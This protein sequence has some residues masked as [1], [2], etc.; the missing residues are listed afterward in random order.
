MSLRA[1]HHGYT[2]QDLVTGIALVDLLLGTATAI[3]V[4]V[5]GFDGDRFDDLTIRYEDNRR[6]RIQIKHTTQDRE[7]SK[8]SFSADS[9]SLKL[10]ILS[11]SLL[12]DLAKHPGTV[13]RV[14]V[15]DGTP[16]QDLAEVLKPVGSSTD[17]G[18][19][20]PGFKTQSFRF[21]REQL[22]SRSPWKKL[23]EHLSDSE[24][25]S[26]CTHLIVD[27]NAPSS[28]VDMSTPGPAERALLR[29]V[30]EEL[31]AGRPPNAERA[32]EDVAL[33]LAYAATAARTL[34][35]SVARRD[36]VP[37]IGL[38]VDFGAVAEGHPIETNLA[39][40]RVRAVTDMRRHVSL[41][42][43]R[44]G[45][46]VVTGEPGA[47][48]SW[49]CQELAASYRASHW[50]V[51][52]HHCWL[53]ANDVDRDKRALTEVVVGSLLRQLEQAAPLATANLRPRFAATTEAL[54]A[55]LAACQERYPT[56]QVLLIVDGLDHVDRVLGR[57]SKDRLD[58]SQVL[59]DQLAA[60]ELPP[61][62]CLVIASQPGSHLRDARPSTGHTVQMPRMSWNEIRD[63][64]LR[65]RLVGQERAT[66]G[67]STVPTE[68]RNLIDLLHDRS[69]GNA[70]YATYLCRYG[71][72]ISPLDADQ[73]AITAKEVIH[74]L[75]LVPSTAND[76][77]AYYGYLLADLTGDQELAIG[78]LA[79]CDFALTASEL[80][81][82][83][84]EAS[85]I[86]ER[87][88]T[89][90]APVLNSQ[91][92]L[93]GL[94]IHH[95][96]FSRHILRDQ[97]E[98]WI[99]TIREKAAAWLAAK[100]FFSDARAFRHLPE[101]LVRL[102]RY[103]ELKELIKPGFVANAIQMLQPP[104]A[105]KHVV[106]TLARESATRLDWPS[107]TACIETW[108]SI[109]TYESEA[110]S[111][112]LIEYADVV[113]SILGPDVVAE[114]L[115]YEGRPTF[116]ARWGLRLCRSVDR[117]GGSA[118]W[119]AYLRAHKN[120]KERESVTYSSDSDDSLHLAIQLGSLRLTGQKNGIKPGLIDKIAANLDGKSVGDLKALVE[121]FSV[122][123]PPGMMIDVV[124]KMT[125]S[126][127]TAH[128]Y[129]ALA[130]LATE[131]TIGLPDPSELADSAWHLS[132]SANIIRYLS[133]GITP[134]KVLSG[135]GLSNLEEHLH[136][137]TKTILD[138]PSAQFE[139][140]HNWLGLL[141][142]AR[143]IDS[144]I[145]VR[146]IGQLGGSGFYRA[147]LRF[148]AATVGIADD[149]KK[150][151]IKAQT[152]SETVRVAL[153]QL[154]VHA[155]PF[156]GTPR[157]CDLYFVHPL[158]HD[159]VEQS[160]KVV[161][162]ADLEAVVDNL[163]AIGDGTTT[164]LMG[165][166]ENGP[167]ATNDLLAI[168]SRVADDVGVQ[169]VHQVLGVIRQRRN[170]ANT[171]YSV[172]AD[173]ELATAR[174]CVGAGATNEAMECWRRAA[175]LLASYGGH[176]DPTIYE[177]MD[178]IKDLAAVDVESAR[179]SLARILDASYLVRQHTDGRGTSNVPNSWW[180]TL[181]S[182]DPI[183]SA[184]DAANVLV[185][186]PGFEDARAQTVYEKLLETQ[187]KAADPIALAS[188]R[189]AA[190]TT[191]RDPNTDLLLL[192]RL[193]TEIG[194]STASSSVITSYANNVAASYDDQPLMYAGERTQSVATSELISE[195]LALGG[196]EFGIRKAHNNQRRNSLAKDAVPTAADLKQRLL[197]AQRPDLPEG[198]AGAVAAARDYAR[199]DY[200]HNAYAPRW[201]IDALVN[202][203]G[204]RVFEATQ[205][206]GRESGIDLLDDVA[207]ELSVY[208]DNE[209]FA[210]L[211]EGLAARCGSATTD[212][213]SVASY[214]LVLAFTRIRGGGGWRRFAGTERVNL[215]IKAHLLDAET[216]E[217]TLAQAVITIMTLGKES[218]YGVTQ[219][220]VA[221]LAAQPSR[222]PDGTAIDCWNA[223]C[224]VLLDRMH[225]EA[226]KAHHIYKA[227]PIPDS[228]GEL[229]VAL[230]TLSLAAISQPKRS[231]L[232][233]ALLAAA[234]LIAARPKVAQQALVPL[235]GHR[236][237]AGR[238]TWLLEIVA[239]FLPSGELSRS[240]SEAL[241]RLSQSEKL[242]VRVLASKI[243]RS[244]KQNVAH[245]PATVP[246]AQSKRPSNG[247]DRGSLEDA[248]LLVNEMLADRL[249]EIG[250]YP[251]LFED[252]V[253]G[254]A[255][256]VDVVSERVRQQFEH[257]RSGHS[258]R[259]P[260]AFFA[261]EE[262]AEDELQVAAAGVRATLAGMGLIGDPTA[263]EE[264]IAQ[265]LSLTGM[266]S[267]R[268]E[269]SQVARPVTRA[270]DIRW[271]L[272]PVPWLGN[273]MLWP[274]SEA[275]A[276]E[277]TRNL[278][279]VLSRGVLVEENPYRG[280]V[281]L[282]LIE[283]MRT[284][285]IDY[286][287]APARNLFVVTGL[288]TDA[289][290][291]AGSY[292]LSASPPDLWVR[293]YG[294]LM[295]GLDSQRARKTLS[296]ARGP[297]VALADQNERRVGPQRGAGLHPFLLSP[298]IEVV[299]ALALRPASPADRYLLVDDA[300]PAA[301]CRQWGSFLIHD[302]SYSDLVPAVH[303]ADLILRRDLFDKVVNMVGSER[304][305]LGLTGHH[306]SDDKTDE[307]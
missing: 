36:V 81:E 277:K 252:V 166:A 194:T 273:D 282:A 151:V 122:C 54:E 183:A 116:S 67:P 154:V 229:D 92:G 199:K 276:L 8:A 20:L 101:L 88:L 287:A 256:R 89:K 177:F 217:R 102:D 79:L 21:D 165:M 56:R 126:D 178:S 97:P 291:S 222:Q 149:V 145:P 143:E 82:M 283:R 147:W 249:D 78:T 221:A 210:L 167:L 278:T 234:L 50:I 228:D 258:K 260:D 265:D 192:K 75:G 204:W 61:G 305:S 300:G 38:T 131:G 15:R 123:L 96:S 171:M 128:V 85:L 80:S 175:K 53:G 120:A 261:D 76:L 99:T 77:D 107:L 51:A 275:V 3:D 19:P 294:D 263:I 158:I 104:E 250:E 188:L 269:A 115:L 18:D 193:Q 281:Q 189:L 225:G 176:K 55:A 218:T 280:W 118:P 302:G 226:E 6:V 46:I 292:P 243:L 40:S 100:G 289:S 266:W 57:T 58:P 9:R 156:T 106:S 163:I 65:H 111:D 4:D 139:A 267:L 247:L 191:W 208:T 150:G 274:P 272:D 72:K 207:R 94:K 186:E 133:H 95:E 47:G 196:S 124:A 90:L 119:D 136:V 180:E 110:L 206:G 66:D 235:L 70:L 244:Q 216:A 237:D 268:D 214:C 297:I 239:D 174:I 69:G 212:L 41:V 114:R 73:S 254:I 59:V 152:A 209:V 12:V 135:L 5:K 141:T 215:W 37:R 62:V 60:I 43:P 307:G 64:A 164:S 155:Q 238:M 29:R 23:V 242:S 91:P 298:R 74:R 16:D 301:L 134:Q 255:R 259:I 201:N 33:S 105:L 86:L 113:V 24:L 48:K 44:G 220:I 198:A 200:S 35:G 236:L 1:T 271:S 28:T 49:L 169:A 30:M 25:D 219:S 231:D 184:R 227:T 279:E 161:E 248:Q 213:N 26:V 14:V 140:V 245:P 253:A 179:K 98:A 202:A 160:L 224:D 27:T 137:S 108:K 45:R 173:F 296:L 121:V 148:A 130:Q 233:R 132:P 63:L 142:L 190:G 288:E 262:A 117:A 241:D 68:E 197:D 52:R 39:V 84:P 31:G 129:L 71:A 103:T 22:R 195:V 306:W 290:V 42:S 303:G 203:V 170:D 182:V 181:A 187:V 270:E 257:L 240:L 112:T 185:A 162:S 32:P 304:L 125:D 246:R 17:P 168:L 153:E 83:L 144:S 159:V 285:A 286:P 232:R 34:Q 146:L 295:P 7:L 13:Y 299:A 293:H 211:G 2:Y 223:G 138:A 264:E 205:T 11:D 10:N 251:R 230:A 93:G 284:L 157:A 109:D 87:A 127:R 172:M